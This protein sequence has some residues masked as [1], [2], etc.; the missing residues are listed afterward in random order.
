MP[1]VTEYTHCGPSPLHYKPHSLR[2]FMQ[3][4][5]GKV[6]SVRRRRPT[7]AHPPFRA[8]FCRRDG[9]SH[10]VPG[11]FPVFSMQS[12]ACPVAAGGAA[13]LRVR[14]SGQGQ[15]GTASPELWWQSGNRSGCRGGESRLGEFSMR[16]Q[17]PQPLCTAFPE[18]PLS[19]TLLAGGWG[20]ISFLQRR[21]GRRHAIAWSS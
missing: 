11:T 21:C 15:D 1:T 10:E 5:S 16:N 2:M 18:T 19:W 3:T 14:S 8:S 6:N 17:L 12:F 20:S 7:D 13:V 4:R 9:L